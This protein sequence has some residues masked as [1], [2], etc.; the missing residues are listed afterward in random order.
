V[1]FAQLLPA[2]LKELP[3]NQPLNLDMLL[4]SLIRL[5]PDFMA[6]P[7]QTDELSPLLTRLAES[8]KPLSHPAVALLNQ[9]TLDALF[10]P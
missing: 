9:A 10:R 1:D 6:T 7:W 2:W 4:Q 5:A 8:G 3:R